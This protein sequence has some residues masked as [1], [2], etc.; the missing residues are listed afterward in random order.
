MRLGVFHYAA[1]DAQLQPV[2]RPG[3]SIGGLAMHLCEMDGS[4][5]ARVP[6]ALVST[7]WARGS[8]CG[9]VRTRINFAVL[10][11]DGEL[12]MVIGMEENSSDGR[13]AAAMHRHRA[14]ARSTNLHQPQDNLSTNGPPQP[15]SEC[16]PRPAEP[17]TISAWQSGAAKLDR[18]PRPARPWEIGRSI[19]TGRRLRHLGHVPGLLQANLC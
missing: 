4:Y 7:M 9:T 16:V 14:D 18:R 10:P 2:A 6:R 17:I 12:V 3:A 11:A 5:M 13:R 8:G 19:A 15:A 1:G